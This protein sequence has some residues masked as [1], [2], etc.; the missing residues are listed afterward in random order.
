MNFFVTLPF[1]RFA[2]KKVDFADVY[3]E[4]KKHCYI[5]NIL[6]PK[7]KSHA[8]LFAYRILFEVGPSSRKNKN[9]ICTCVFPVMVPVLDENGKPRKDVNDEDILVAKPDNEVKMVVV[10]NRNC[11]ELTSK[12]DCDMILS[13]E[14]A[15]LIALKIMK[16]IIRL[17]LI[18]EPRKFALTPLASAVYT[19]RSIEAMAKIMDIGLD[20]MMVQVNY[21]AHSSGYLLD[22]S[23]VNCAVACALFGTRNMTLVEKRYRVIERTMNGYIRSGAE[24]DSTHMTIYALFAM[25]GY[26]DENTKT[27]LDKLLKQFQSAKVCGAMV[28]DTE[29]VLV[30]LMKYLASEGCM[31]PPELLKVFEFGVDADLKKLCD[32]NGIETD[33]IE[34]AVDWSKLADKLGTYFGKPNIEKMVDLFMRIGDALHP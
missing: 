15:Y 19:P 20:D 10:A 32:E 1:A 33:G 25:G 29:R 12:R 30:R 3:H 8:G 18:S 13:V 14:H 5:H 26:F 22:C 28:N 27:V 17:A 4:F 23:D 6:E 7:D 2:G 31:N 9:Y 11:P 34:I 24:H 21:S 16:P